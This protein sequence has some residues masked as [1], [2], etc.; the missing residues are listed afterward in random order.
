M[1]EAVDATESATSCGTDAVMMMT[2]TERAERRA[3][4]DD[5]GRRL[6]RRVG[7]RQDGDASRP[8]RG[9]TGRHRQSLA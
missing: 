7:A 2:T 6:V 8:A 3:R 1:I 4:G 5:E 9:G